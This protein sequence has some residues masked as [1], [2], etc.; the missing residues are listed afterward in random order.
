MGDRKKH[1]NSHVASTIAEAIEA[2]GTSVLSFLESRARI[3]TM[4]E[5]EEHLQATVQDVLA[6]AGPY[7]EQADARNQWSA[8]QEY[9]VIP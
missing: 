3:L 7:V 8:Y 5:R 1:R 6:Y 2:A 4:E 9:P